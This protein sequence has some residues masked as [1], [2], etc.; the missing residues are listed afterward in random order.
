[1]QSI[2]IIFNYNGYRYQ[3]LEIV[4][5]NLRNCSTERISGLKGKTS[6]RRAIRVFSRS[7]YVPRRDER[8]MSVPVREQLSPLARRTR[9]DESVLHFRASE[10]GA[11]GDGFTRGSGPPLAPGGESSLSHSPW[12]RGRCGWPLRRARSFPCRGASAFDTCRRGSRS[13]SWTR[14]RRRRRRCCLLRLHLLLCHSPS[15]S[16]VSC[17]ARNT[18]CVASQSL[19]ISPPR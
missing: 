6:S 18:R 5:I 16:Y 13:S 2:D 17:H 4:V 3:T 19:K 8:F 1:M 12:L 14:R 10:A 9:A 7:R 11:R 15:R